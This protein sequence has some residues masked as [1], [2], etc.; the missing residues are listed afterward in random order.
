MKTD[1]YKNA[2]NERKAELL[3]EVK[4][5][6]TYKAKQDFY[7][8]LHGTDARYTPWETDTWSKTEAGMEIGVSFGEMRQIINDTSK[9]NMPSDY[10][11]NGDT[12]SGTR[13][14]K[15]LDYLNDLSYSDKQKLQLYSVLKGSGSENSIQKMQNIMNAGLS[16]Y[17][18]SKVKQEHTSIDDQDHS[19]NNTD[20][21]NHDYFTKWLNDEG[22]SESEIEAINEN[23]PF[24]NRM[25][26]QTDSILKR[27]TESGMDY[28]AAY[29][30]ANKVAAIEPE[31]GEDEVSDAQKYNV[32]LDDYNMST[33]E[34]QAAI[35]AIAGS[36]SLFGE[37]DEGAAQTM[38]DLF[39]QTG[40][41]S[42]L[43]AN[44]GTNYSVDGTKYDYTEDQQKAYNQAY[45]QML[46]GISGTTVSSTKIMENIRDIAGEAGKY[47]AL[48]QAGQN[49]DLSSS[50]YG[51]YRK[52]QQA[53][54][55]G[56]DLTRYCEIKATCNSFSSGSKKE[57][58]V[59]YLKAQGLTSQQYSFFYS[60][61]MGYK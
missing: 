38:M 4:S 3:S 2:T 27:L 9:E 13:D 16:F 42:A 5:Y 41:T 56:L 25:R 54:N 47:A 17:E 52:A 28:D 37:L 39:N 20:M 58:V 44:A 50:D 10:D 32:I 36:Y 31:D 30:V 33:G 48:Q 59:A 24:Y 18:A 34:R 61:V 57:K 7:E 43:S 19:I 55:A 29:E 53:M 6:T 49:P 26:Q 1:A 8:R 35:A 22:F 60:T 15:I 51:A 46:N 45:I 21:N 14:G 23:Y 40:Q 11:E 12:I